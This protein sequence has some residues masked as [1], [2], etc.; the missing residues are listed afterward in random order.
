MNVLITNHS[1]RHLGGTELF[2]KEV[3]TGLRDRGHQVCV[4][5]TVVGEV[6][7][8]IEDAGVPVV[9]DPAACPFEPDIIHAQHHLPAMA[10]IALH[11]RVPVVYMLHGIV[12][13][14]ERPVEHPRILRY[15]APSP[16][17]AWWLREK[18]GIEC[19]EVGVVR[20]GFDPER[21]REPRPQGRATRR[22]L[23]YHNS[24]DRQGEE[25]REIAAACGA[26][27]YEVELIG[28]VAG[29]SCERPEEILPSYDLVFASG[30]SAIEAMAC[31][32]AVIPLAVG[33]IAARVHPAIYERQQRLNFAPVSDNIP[34]DRAEIAR[35]IGRIDAGETAEVTESVRANVTLGATLTALEN[36]YAAAVGTG[37][38]EDLSAER[39][40][41]ANYLLGMA[42]LV[43]GSDLKR[44]ELLAQKERA[45]SRADK[46]QKRAGQDRE[47]IEW[48]GQ[49]LESGNWWR[50]RLWRKMRRDWEGR[51]GGSDP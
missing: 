14:E 15:L 4:F 41:V 7:K 39:A 46:W 1:L 40:S 31:G 29:N 5:T 8:A 50:R 44:G 2:V 45:S 26:A 3:S 35:E 42:E 36:E 38:V 51:A 18:C 43:T 16:D 34:L 25:F 17:F 19:E 47:H 21:F 22:A 30:R 9:T 28:R 32:C 49:R 10:A 37:V 11:P 12:P 20:N 27:G 24:L 13:W 48:L 33:A 23:V 6:S